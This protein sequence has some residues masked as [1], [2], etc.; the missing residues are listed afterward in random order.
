MSRISCLL[1]H[2]TNRAVQSP[3][4]PTPRIPMTLTKIRIS[5]GLLYWSDSSR[6]GPMPLSGWRSG[7]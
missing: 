2:P 4:Q 3:D 5:G 6:W 1:R 7:C